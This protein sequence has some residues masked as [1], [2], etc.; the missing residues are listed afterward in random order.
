MTKKA[1]IIYK[2]GEVVDVSTLDGIYRFGKVNWLTTV[3][4]EVTDEQIKDIE[5]LKDFSIEVKE[6]KTLKVKKSKD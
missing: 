5:E 4:A 2:G 6:E 1:K 3:T